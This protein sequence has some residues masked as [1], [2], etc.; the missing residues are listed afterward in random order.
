MKKVSDQTQ[1]PVEFA[2]SQVGG[3]ASALARIAGVTPQGVHLWK[4]KGVVPA[5]KAN[6]LSKKLGIPR[7]KLNP[8]VF[9]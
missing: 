2:I 9:G 3:N 5:A 7:K 6:L 8:E 4:R 1:T